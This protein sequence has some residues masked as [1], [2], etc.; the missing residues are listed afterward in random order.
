SAVRCAVSASDARASTAA[1]ANAS[2]QAA[3]LKSCLL[4]CA[5]VRVEARCIGS[6]CH[7]T[8]PIREVGTR[9]TSGLGFS[10]SLAQELVEPSVV[11]V[12]VIE[13]Q[14]A[15]GFG[16]DGGSVED[17][18]WDGRREIISLRHRI[19]QRGLDGFRTP[20]ALC[21]LQHILGQLRGLTDSD[22]AVT[23]RATRALEEVDIRGRV[24]VDIVRIRHDELDLAQRVL[25]AG[26]LPQSKLP[27]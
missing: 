14:D 18:D 21:T 17:Q 12:D 10:L 22:A 9:L 24:Q 26:S 2:K 27:G 3:P 23:E 5:T 7:Y 15:I 8:G 13:E 20:F 6:F 19:A 11:A 25:R 1:R 16:D 4:R